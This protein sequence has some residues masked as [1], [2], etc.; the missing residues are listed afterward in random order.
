MKT[1]AKV[2]AVVLALV[3][4]ASLAAC[5]GS[6]SGSDNGSDNSNASSAI[7][8]SWENTEYGTA[9]SFNTDGTGTLTGDGYNF[10]YTYVDKGNAIE[11]TYEGGS[12][13]QTIDYTLID[14]ILTLGGIPYTKK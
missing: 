6:D 11:V 12:E 1:I 9:C 14:G 3:M 10:N 13:V 5:G 4:L 7:I 8:G 2:L